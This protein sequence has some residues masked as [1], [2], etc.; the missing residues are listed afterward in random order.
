V[1]LGLSLK[2]EEEEAVVPGGGD[3]DENDV[4]CNQCGRFSF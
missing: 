3:D 2:G 4:S 1:N